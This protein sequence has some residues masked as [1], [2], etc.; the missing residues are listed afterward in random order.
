[1]THSLFPSHIVHLARQLRSELVALRR[2]FHQYPELSWE[3]EHTAQLIAGRL[4]TLGLTVR[5]D[6]GGHGLIAQLVGELP[7]PTIAYRADMDAL[8]LQD[9]LK[10]AYRSTAMGINHACGHDAHMTIAVGVAKI[11]SSL[12]DNLHGTIR[13][14]FQ[15]AEEALDGAQAMIACGALGEP[16]PKAVL[17]L[18]AFPLPVGSIGLVP[19]PCLAGMDEFQVKFDAPDAMLPN[20]VDMALAALSALSNQTPPTTPHAFDTLIQ[21]MTTGE[22][23]KNSIYL[24]CWQ[25]AVDSGSVAHI[26]G[27]VS[28]ADYAARLDVKR[29]ITWKLDSVIQG[30]DARYKV[31]YSFT[32]PPMINDTVLTRKTRSFVEDVIGTENVKWFNAPYPFAHEDFALYAQQVPAALLWLGTANHDLEI[33]SLL[34]TPDYD[35][36]EDALVTGAAVMSYILLQ[37]SNVLP[38]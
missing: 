35:I 12:R 31:W 29:R 38:A 26:T 25:N 27:L 18:H 24:S 11:L 19:G 28:T 21:R 37:L 2:Y 20:L 32:N 4:E 15:P 33:H 23:L 10:T 1:M 3:E 22:D 17:A 6:V 7:G 5:R 36:D 14:L 13:F 9:D 8:P 16:I 34:H 30:T